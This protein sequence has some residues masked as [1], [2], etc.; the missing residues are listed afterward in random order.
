MI[1]DNFKQVKSFKSSRVEN[2]YN[3]ILEKFI[4]LKSKGELD[5]NEGISQRSLPNR[6]GPIVNEKSAF[7]MGNMRKF[8]N[9]ILDGKIGGDLGYSESKMVLVIFDSHDYLS[10]TNLSNLMTD[11]NNLLNQAWLE[12]EDFRA[13][14]DYIQR[15]Q[16]FVEDLAFL[17]LK[18]LQHIRLLIKLD[19]QKVFKVKDVSQL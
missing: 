8:R 16:L 11:I 18:V 14:M 10:E 13:K 1:E 3:R 19:K 9:R 17:N 6:E 2:Y 15:C 5:E 7:Y 4:K 12:T